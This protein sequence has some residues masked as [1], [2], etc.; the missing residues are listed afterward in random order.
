[1]DDAFRN[2]MTQGYAL[3]QPGVPLGSPM[4][5]AEL[6]PEVRVQVANAML[7]RHGLIA[8]AT[9]TGKTKT[10]QLLA[11]ELSQ[12]GIPVFVADIKGDLTG[13]AAPG[14][15]TNQAV[16]DRAASMGW[17]YAPAGAPGGVPVAVGQAGR[18]G[19]RQ[20]ALLRARCC[21]ARCSTSTRPRRRSCRWCSSTATTSRSRSLTCRTWR[22]TLKFLSSDDGKPIL[23]EYGGMSKS[24]VGVLLRALVVLEQEGADV[25]FGEPSFDVADLMRV[26][27]DGKGVISVLELSDVMAKPR[28]FSTFMLWLLAQLYQTLPEAG[29]LPQPKLAFF[30][31]E[32]H[33]LFDDASKALMDQVELTVRLIRSKGVGVYFV[34]Q[35]PTDVPSSVLAQLGNRVQHALRAFTPEDADALRKTARTF[36]TS[37]H[38]DVEKT[39]TSL[40]T[41]EALV[42]VLSPRGVPTPLAATRLLPPDSL[43]AALP[44]DQF[45]AK[46]ASGMLGGKYGTRL[47][48]ES[49]H[50]IIGRQL[51]A[52][53]AAAAAAAGVDTAVAATMTAAELK[54]A[55]KARAAETARAEKE[56]LKAAERQQRAEQKAL[57]QAQREML[58]EQQRMARE[59]QAARERAQRAMTRSTS[60]RSR[61]SSKEDPATTDDPL[62]VRDAVRQVAS[63]AI[64][65]GDGTDTQQHPGRGA[66]RGRA[67]V[68]DARAGH[69]GHPARRSARAPV[70]P[71]R[72][73][74]RRAVSATAGPPPRPV[75]TT[76]DPHP[77]GTAPRPRQ[78]RQR[79]GA[80]S[81]C[82]RRHR[83]RSPARPCPPRAASDQTSSG[84]ES[85][86]AC[87][88]SAV[89]P[90][91][92][93][94]RDEQRRVRVGR[95][96]R[97]RSRRRRAHRQA[98][99]ARPRSIP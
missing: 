32:A 98:A 91:K 99:P 21:W 54:A 64:L 3:T 7:N 83:P 8:G 11:G 50:E 6:L 5:G 58:Q 74:G 1:M 33:L 36:P 62:R 78:G 73:G 75:P 45:A 48:R 23:E 34:T 28:L 65:C 52:A 15:A 19:A 85:T 93:I 60:G 49:A 77:P 70:G 35:S 87:A 79:H 86:N 31:D 43:M 27:P 14:D 56:A 41:G 61:A 92:P 30:F 40:G 24:S 38:Y 88:W 18:P 96:P 63:S 16:L 55:Q 20:R 80:R 29:D 94:R 17:T 22:T 82:G 42:T 25:F 71:W 76:V 90:R 47:D 10:L 37:A 66:P 13:L 84:N 51:D 44:P 95:A 69:L 46:V 9:G 39:I 72:A 2:E 59:E 97:G 57:E 89:T 4:L 53:R 67:G 68:P 26:T 81:G 12:A